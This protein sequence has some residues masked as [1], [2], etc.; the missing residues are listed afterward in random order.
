MTFTQPPV[1]KKVPKVHPYVH[2]N[3]APD[4]YDWLKD[5]SKTSKSQDIL[6]YITLENEYCQK[7]VLDPISDL[8]EKVYQEFLSRIEESEVALPSF[9]SPY[10]YYT[11]TIEGQQYPIYC[12]KFES[13]DAAEEQYLNMNLIKDSEFLNV[14]ST[15]VSPNHRLL[16]YVLDTDGYEHCSIFVKD[17]ESGEMLPDVIPMTS[18][19]GPIWSADS[20]SLY[21]VSIDEQNNRPDKL[22]RHDLEEPASSDVVLYNNEDEK[23]YTSITKSSSDRFIFL[24]VESPLTSEAHFIDLEA[25]EPVLRCFCPR[26]FRHSY[27]VYHQG[28]YF[29]ILTNGGGKFLNR[30]L[31]RVG[32]TDTSRHLWEDVLPYDPYTELSDA[33]AFKDFLV[34]QERK[35]GLLGLRIVSFDGENFDHYA[36]PFEEEI[37]VAS[38]PWKDQPNSYGGHSF[39]FT[40]TSCLV[41]LKMMEFDVRTKESTV[42]QQTKGFDPSEYTMRRVFVPIPEATRVLAPF[43]TPV[44]DTIPVTLVYKTDSFKNDGS[45]KIFMAGYGSYGMPVDGRFEGKIFSLVDRGIVYAVAH[46]RGG[47]DLGQAWYETGKLSH[48]KNAFTDF[49]ACAE[50]LVQEEKITKHE[51]MALFGNSAGG[52]LLGAVMNL[53]PD[54]A[55]AVVAG[56]PW[57][58]PLNTS[59]DA[60]IPMVTLDWEEIGNPNEK[61]A[62]DYLQS[63]SPYENIRENVKYPSVLLTAGLKD[64]HVPYW[65]AAKWVAK[66]RASNTNGGAGDPHQSVIGFKCSMSGGHGGSGGRYGQYRESA[67]KYAF[68]I[69]ELEKSEDRQSKPKLW[70]KVTKVTTTSSTTSSGSTTTKKVRTITEVAYK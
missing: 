13:M 61:E 52:L 39:Q 70:T 67:E 38:L 59:L 7:N 40:Y 54:I 29:Y 60:S 24:A 28:D 37:Y 31:Q 23:F 11:R 10:W 47:G 33:N 57:L 68:L 35:N 43:G 58:D 9:K 1:A 25:E 17:L 21:Y 41:P 12:R 50:F 32:I 22:R 20:K 56:V 3:G 30:K 63:Y 48:K 19:D 49:V 66:M 6:D 44:S 2:G 18:M 64:S 53:K 42:L 5:Q 51:L 65:E 26:E 14:L 55:C 27:K 36:V 8:T 69:H 45:N 46:V 16:A 62:F 15:S 4:N 34:I